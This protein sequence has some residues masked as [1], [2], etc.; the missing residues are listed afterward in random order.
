MYL[1]YAPTLC[2]TMRPTRVEKSTACGD[3]GYY[4]YMYTHIYTVTYIRLH[5][6]VCVCIHVCIDI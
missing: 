3:T 2:D 4:T 5:M 1:S 6:Y